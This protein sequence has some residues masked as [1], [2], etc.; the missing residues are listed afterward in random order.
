MLVHANLGTIC[1]PFFCCTAFAWYYTAAVAQCGS[2]FTAH[3]LGGWHI[4]PMKSYA[5]RQRIPSIRQ[6]Q[7]FRSKEHDPLHFLCLVTNAILMPVS[8]SY[9]AFSTREPFLLNS[10]IIRNRMEPKMSISTQT[11]ACTRSDTLKKLVFFS[12][13]LSVLLPTFTPIQG[14]YSLILDHI[15]SRY[16]AAT[17]IISY[18]TV[19][20]ASP[21]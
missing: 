8:G 20:L 10:N 3:G 4:W 6:S 12:L 13:V 17:F 2:W 9:T 14:W 15:T 7:H 16:L 11:L 1:S 5:S 21:P 18:L 19:S